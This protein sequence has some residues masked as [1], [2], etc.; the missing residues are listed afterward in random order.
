MSNISIKKLLAQL[1]ALSE[2]SLEDIALLP[3]DSPFEVNAIIFGPAGTPYE[4]GAFRMRLVYGSDYPAASPRGYFLTKIFHPNVSPK[5]DICVNT[6]KR[7]WTPDV[8]VSHILLIVKCL[9]ISPGPDSALNEEAGRLL[10]E[11][12]EEFARRARIITSVHALKTPVALSELTAEQSS[13][14]QLS[15]KKSAVLGTSD[16]NRPNLV[17]TVSDTADPSTTK[18][19]KVSGDA[20]MKKKASDTKKKSSLK[21]L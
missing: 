8:T 10:M 6:L 14:Q 20:V 4:D 13:K 16:P 5:G 18:K 15:Y 17:H 7:D 11:S 1:K 21:R 2:E 19:T 12:Y 9:L 3:S